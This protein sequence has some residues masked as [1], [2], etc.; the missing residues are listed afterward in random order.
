MQHDWPLTLPWLAESRRA[1][2]EIARFVAERADLLTRAS[3]KASN[4]TEQRAR[5]RAP[6]GAVS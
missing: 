4:L 3:A 2:A 6:K 1:W 5:T